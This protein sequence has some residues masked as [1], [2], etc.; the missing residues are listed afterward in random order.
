MRCSDPKNATARSAGTRS[1]LPLLLP[2]AMLV[3]AP[4]AAAEQEGGPTVQQ[5]V[6]GV[7][8]TYKG[9]N[10]LKADFTQVAR[11]AA[12]GDGQAQQ[13]VVMLA[14]PRKMRWD[15][16]VPDDKLFV[17]DGSTMWVH[18]PADKQVFISDDL[19]GGGAGGPDE[20]LQ[21][22]DKLDELFSVS[23]IPGAPAGSVRLELLP[24]K[25]AQFKKLQLLLALDG[26]TLQQLV[27]VDTFDNATELSFS[28]IQVNPTLADSVFTFQVPAGTEVIRADGL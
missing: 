21:N 9:V 27:V 11:S 2:G 19:G 4:A 22:L 17:T 12:M 7:E 6:D 20:L 24:K 15:F 23:I 26:Y 16:N 13:G 14:R 28:N 18:T 1:L 5:V 8:S 25:Q 3:L 10:A